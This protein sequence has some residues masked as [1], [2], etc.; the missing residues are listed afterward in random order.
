MKLRFS[1]P[2]KNMEN[3]QIRYE[4]VEKTYKIPKDIQAKHDKRCEII[5][6]LVLPIAVSILVAILTTILVNFIL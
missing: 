5:L 4:F 6:Y 3:R 2:E 1:I